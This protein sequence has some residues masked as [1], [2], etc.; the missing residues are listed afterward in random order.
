M[1]TKTKAEADSFA[2]HNG[3]GEELLTKRQVSQQ[4]KLSPRSIDRK[5]SQGSFPK[6]FK[7]GSLVRWR[8]SSIEQWI[9]SN[10]DQQ[11]EK[12]CRKEADKLSRG[13]ES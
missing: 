1:A 7:I 9:R 12:K 2:L 3:N 11:W 6:G 4:L 8:R 5:I 10:E 13:V